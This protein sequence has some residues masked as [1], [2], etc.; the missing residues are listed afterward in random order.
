M[1]PDLANRDETATLVLNNGV[2]EEM[3]EN[4]CQ[5]DVRLFYMHQS[6]ALLI[7]RRHVTTL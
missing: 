4:R 3:A 7:S 2:G 6:P 5:I 1:A